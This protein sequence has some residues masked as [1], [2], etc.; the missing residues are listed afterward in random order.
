M[1]GRSESGDASGAVGAGVRR[2]RN[3]WTAT[4]VGVPV[5]SDC[6]GPAT[7]GFGVGAGPDGMALCLQ[8]ETHTFAFLFLG[9]KPKYKYW[10]GLNM[11]RKFSV[12]VI[13]TFI[14]HTTLRLYAAM[15]CLSAFLLLQKVAEPFSLGYARAAVCTGMRL[16]VA[17]GGMKAGLTGL[18][19]GRDTRGGL[20]VEG[21]LRPRR[22]ASSRRDS[23]IG[24]E[25]GFPAPAL[26]RSWCVPS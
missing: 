19:G 5:P 4:G 1:Q 20:Q 16:R 14:R 10:E 15:W 7:P 9:Y 3:I 17:A 21:M 2:L 25:V 6:P 22:G 23:G 8:V 18:C 24:P 13:A 11:L 12:I 26:C